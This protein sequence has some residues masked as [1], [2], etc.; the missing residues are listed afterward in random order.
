MILEQRKKLKL[1]DINCGKYGQVELKNGFESN[2]R[3]SSKVKTVVKKL[4]GLRHISIGNLKIFLIL[5]MVS[6]SFVNI[7]EMHK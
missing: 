1:N 2:F 4:N 3:S 6:R 5:Q 7:L